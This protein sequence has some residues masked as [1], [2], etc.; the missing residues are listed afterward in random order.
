MAPLP[1]LVSTEVAPSVTEPL[2]DCA[3]VVVMVAP[4]STEAPLSVRPAPLL[5]AWFTVICGAYTVIGPAMLTN[6]FKVMFVKL[7]ALPSVKPL[8]LVS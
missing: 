6:L 4:L 7:P 2:K 1:V 8:R 3:P 5:S